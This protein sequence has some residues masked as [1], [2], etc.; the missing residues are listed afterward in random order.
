MTSKEIIAILEQAAQANRDDPWRV[1]NLIELSPPGEVVMTGDLHG[2]LRNF[3]KIS[4]YAQLAK[5]PDRHLVLHEL[6]H[7][8]IDP[9]TPD[10]CHSYELVAQA[11]RLKLEFPGQVHFLM[12]N[13]AMAQLTRGEIIK[14]G[15][16]MV[17]ALMGGVQTTYGP[18]GHHVL[19]A[20]DQ[21]ILSMP[22]AVRTANGFWLS[23]SLPSARHLP[24]FDDEIFHKCLTLQDMNTSNSIHAFLWDRRHSADLLAELRQRWG[25]DLFIVG[26]QP[27]AQGWSEPQPGLF[28]LAC[29]HAHGCFVCCDLGQRYETKDVAREIRRL[30]AIT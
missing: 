18:R 1:G 14:N 25:V 15:R 6:I 26:H 5:H 9:Q 24:T 17:R 11:A 27:Q 21:F 16:A 2:H 22:L 29:D 19:Q 3:E 30:A 20:L 7:G 13:H 23:H 28:V 4:D 10:E 8:V 12:G